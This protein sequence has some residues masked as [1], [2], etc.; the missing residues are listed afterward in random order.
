MNQYKVGQDEYIFQLYSIARCFICGAAG[1]KGDD[2][3][4]HPEGDQG[5]I[6]TNVVGVWDGL[7]NRTPVPVGVPWIVVLRGNHQVVRS[8]DVPH[9]V[10]GAEGGDDIPVIRALLQ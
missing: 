7:H 6:G 10:H 9:H 2:S 8:S 1:A 5:G 4:G 3:P